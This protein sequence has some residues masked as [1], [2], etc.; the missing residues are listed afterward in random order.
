MSRLI[1]FII[2][3]NIGSVFSEEITQGNSLEKKYAV[4]I[5]AAN[6]SYTPS[7]FLERREFSSHFGAA[8]AIENNR[9]KE[10]P[11]SFSYYSKALN[12]F[13]EYSYYKANFNDMYYFSPTFS[14]RRGDITYLGYIGYN[15]PN[16][17]RRENKLNLY[18]KY[19][20][21]KNNHFFAG[22]GIRNIYKEI[23]NT[24]LNFE[25]YEKSDAY[26]LEL[27]LRYR[28]DFLSSF[29][30]SFTVEP[31]YT[32]G[33]LTIKDGPFI[34]PVNKRIYLFPQNYSFVYFWGYD[35]DM[36]LSYKIDDNLSFLIGYN[37]I[38]TLTRKQ[39]RYRLDSSEFYFILD[40]ANG[41]YFTPPPIEYEK[42]DDNIKNFYLGIKAEF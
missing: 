12:L 10:N 37:Y 8:S 22:V 23:S 41:R 1:L 17:K 19:S 24:S 36:N 3:F 20:Q 13:F 31:F 27:F 16:V 18:R 32:M 5:K 9:T 2:L 34:A 29:S 6:F 21:Q 35:G 42:T 11:L 40:E 33:K 28:L 7:E 15:L 30:I 26:G 25:S 38:R 39:N 4:T 14:N